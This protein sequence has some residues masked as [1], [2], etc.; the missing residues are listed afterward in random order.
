MKQ[1]PTV[2]KWSQADIGRYVYAF[3]KLDGSNIRAEW[4]KKRGFYKFGTRH[5]MLGEDHPLLGSAIGL[6]KAKY[7]QDLVKVF[8]D[9]SWT[10]VVC[11]FEFHGPGSFAGNHVETEEKTV[12]LIDVNVHLMGMIDPK[13]FLEC[14]SHLDIPRVLHHGAFDAD[15]VTQVEDGTL[16][17]MTFEG[18]VCKNSG[19]TFKVKNKAWLT[20]LREKCQDDEA[21]FDRLA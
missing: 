12:T 16:S 15:F 14:F 5:C 18:V 19:T 20:R 8:T 2:P 21:L 10:R 4:G 17:G 13:T 3:D 6:I 9:M 11:F 7:E 1:Y